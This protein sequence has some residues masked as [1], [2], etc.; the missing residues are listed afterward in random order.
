[1]SRTL[2]ELDWSVPYPNSKRNP[3][4]HAYVI[5]HVSGVTLERVHEAAAVWVEEAER[6]D[7]DDGQR[8]AREEHQHH[9]QALTTTEWPNVALVVY[10]WASKSNTVKPNS[11]LSGVWATY[12]RLQISGV[13]GHMG[14]MI[15][16]I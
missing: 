12:Y 10:D 11:S 15:K 5:E 6:V 3:I 1:M 16:S 8:Q 7:V 4:K 9:Q 13:P 2:S 14:N